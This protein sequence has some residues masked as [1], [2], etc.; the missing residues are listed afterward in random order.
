MVS[1][2]LIVSILFAH[3]GG[4]EGLNNSN[5][6]ILTQEQKELLIQM[7]DYNPSRVV[8]KSFQMWPDPTIQKSDLEKTTIKEK[9][10][11]LDL[12]NKDFFDL[13]NYW[14]SDILVTEDVNKTVSMDVD[15]NDDLYMVTTRN[16][17]VH[18]TRGFIYKSTNNGI[19]WYLWH[20]FFIDEEHIIDPSI[21]VTANNIVIVF[22]TFYDV[23]LWAFWIRKDASNS[24]W[25]YIYNEVA[26]DPSIDN[27]DPSDEH[28]LCV[29]FRG[30]GGSNNTT[31]RFT[32]SNDEGQSWSTPDSIC[33]DAHVEWDGAITVAQRGSSIYALVTY[34]ADPRSI[35][36][37]RSTSS[38]WDLVYQIGS[39]S[40]PY[41]R[42]PH[43]KALQYGSESAVLVYHERVGTSP[44]D[45]NLAF[46]YSL[47]TGDIG[48]WNSFYWNDPNFKQVWPQ[49]SVGGFGHDYFYVGFWN[50]HNDNIPRVWTVY[51]SK[52]SLSSGQ[53]KIVSRDA[54]LCGN[55]YKTAINWTIQDTIP[56]VLWLDSRTDGCDIY[57]NTGDLGIEE[58]NTDFIANLLILYQN[59]PNPVS[60]KTIIKY[61]ISKQSKVSLKVFDSSGKE[62]ATILKKEQSV[63]NYKVTW[64][65]ND[66]SKNKLPNGVYFYCLNA[67][68]YKE[69]KKM[70]II[71]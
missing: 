51:H 11:R 32:F 42:D 6:S 63:G 71:R 18:E 66:F 3:T 27:R 4:I 62:V 12:P 47:S 13:P 60:T 19:T 59:K 22:R 29:A 61:A 14:S 44:A 7:R 35:Y 1:T 2:I 9:E 25:T 20:T 64:D 65:I 39:S 46:C 49:L 34:Y 21:C 36:V 8:P 40:G 5:T 10:I 41:R 69:T 50:W 57:C 23:A 53:F 70:V 33:F 43:I 54:S 37:R 55:A 24:G 67:G 45:T 30:R 15:N 68:D 38:G 26:V 58:E 28:S 52:D 48:T 56:L 31:I 16:Y 17:S